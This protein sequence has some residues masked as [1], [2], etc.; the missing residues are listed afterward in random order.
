MISSAREAATGRREQRR[1]Q[2]HDLSR[3]QLLAAA[4]EVFG[5]KGFHDTTLKEVADLAEF[6]VGSVY[7]FFASKDDLFQA[8]FARRGEEFMAEMRAV[9]TDDGVGPLRQLH[10]L[11]DFQVGWFRRHARFARLYL[12]YSSAAML[13]ADREADAVIADNYAE[14]MRLQ[15]E[16]LARGQATG[17]F[18]TGDPEVLAR[19]FS[20]IVS[21][22]QA[23]D[24]AVV[25]DS[26]RGERL[27]LA[28]LHELVE[29]A[30]APA[31]TGRTGTR[32]GRRGR[33]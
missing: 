10:A 28:Q 7:S 25:D 14:S 6:S 13:S 12:R 9:L 15:A 31:P 8:I 5:R 1:L 26:P 22:Y 11:V 21:A 30:F 3:S 17:A 24:P 16:L 19:L 33:R 23:L 4:E 2:H 32:A 29:H 27:P 18:R 20:G